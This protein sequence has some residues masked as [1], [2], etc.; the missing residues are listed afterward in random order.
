LRKHVLTACLVLL[1]ATPSAA[2]QVTHREIVM[3]DPPLRV[4]VLQAAPG[5]P[6]EA[7][8]SNGVVAGVAKP[9]GF[10]RNATGGVNG[11]YFVGSGPNAGDVVGAHV[12]GGEL[13]SEPVD[14]R[15]TLMLSA[16]PLTRPRVTSLSF[17]GSVRIGSRTRALDGVNRLRGVIWGC[18]G[19][20]GD[21]PTQ[22]P[23][24]GIY[25][26]DPSELIQ[27]TPRWGP[28]TPPSA[29]G[30][31]A[32]VQDGEVGRTRSGGGTP[33]PPDGFVL[34]GSGDGARFLQAARG[35]VEVATTLR[36]STGA[37]LLLADLSGV[38]SG[39]P[40]LLD[41]GR[42]ALRTKSEGF[43]RPGLYQRF[44]A[45][46]HPRTLAGVTATG[47]LLLVTVDGRR[48][49][50]STGMTLPEAARLMRNLGARDALNLDGGGSTTM[51][52]GGRVVNRPSDRGGERAVGDGVVLP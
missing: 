17:R 36:T 18:G 21:R 11:A 25:C 8:L 14:G 15:S 12:S 50:Y 34:S 10:A 48:P 28:R 51:V 9:S 45:G 20:G 19:R 30:V 37:P 13:A 27:F 6:A 40:R 32:V 29:G 7:V 26:T 44:V 1:T 42:I 41:R 5:T 2:A 3:K 24:H 33:I 46:R 38:V 4:H 52:I 49:G 43:D 39:G 35:E 47:D 23:V 16:D 22:R 31:E